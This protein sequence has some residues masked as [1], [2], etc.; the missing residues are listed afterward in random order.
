MTKANTLNLIYTSIIASLCFIINQHTAIYQCAAIFTGILVVANTYLLQNRVGDAYKMLLTG[1]SFSIPLYFIMGV[2]DTTI[3]KITIA[4]IASLA[5]TGS[6]SI[7]LTNFFKNT[8]QF[9]LALFASLAISALADGFIMSSYYVAFN[10]FTMSKTISILYKELAFKMLYASIIA[11]TIYSVELTH[12]KQ[13][14]QSV[15]TEE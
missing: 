10:I 14:A 9:S 3:I 7:Y 8:Y 6:L 4:S 12:Q 15:K 11:G 2:S 1:I 5:I 13:K